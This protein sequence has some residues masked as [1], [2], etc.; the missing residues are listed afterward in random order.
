MK[1][2]T[3][4][5]KIPK[6]SKLDAFVTIKNHKEKFPG[7]IECRILNPSKN[8][9]GKVSKNIL[10]KIIIWIKNR[11]QLTQWKNSDEVTA[12]FDEMNCKTQKCFINFDIKNY[13]PSITE[14]HLKNAFNFAKRYISISD[15]DT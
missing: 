4:I 13:Y 14:K 9:L 10:E 1:E 6:Y 2:I 15:E 8:S 12:W 5:K 11:T 3:R 7:K